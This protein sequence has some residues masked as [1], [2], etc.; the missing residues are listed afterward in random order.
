[1]F[2]ADILIEGVQRFS[3]DEETKSIFQSFEG[4]S[5]ALYLRGDKTVTFIVKDARPTALEGEV[6]NPSAIAEIDAIEFTRFIDGR[7]HFAE[8]FTTE[9]GTY[10]E[11]RK[12]KVYDFGGDFMLLGPISDRLMKLYR[13][14]LEFRNMVDNFA[15]P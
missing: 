5:V 8:L 12:G 13:E 2:L 15:P 1:M 7:T 6:Q 10:F 9:F 4:D 3:D 14:D 11:A